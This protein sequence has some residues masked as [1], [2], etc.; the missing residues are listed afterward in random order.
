MYAFLD[1]YKQAADAADLPGGEW[2]KGLLG[3]LT[4]HQAGRAQ[5]LGRASEEKLEPAESFLVKHPV[6]SSIIGAATGGAAGGAAGLG[7]DIGLGIAPGSR[8]GL[9]IGLGGTV[10]G[11]LLG[12]LAVNQM[13]LRKVRQAREE[14]GEPAAAKLDQALREEAASSPTWRAV[15]GLFGPGFVYSG[16]DEQLASLK[17]GTPVKGG[18]LAGAS[19]VMS[20]IPYAGPLARLT[21]GSIMGARSPGI[22]QKA[23]A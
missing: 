14:F 2:Y 15:A 21:A 16:R 11:T 8:T 1:G 13:I 4:S 23:L 18:R 17:K 12:A 3:G 20:H 7:A 9:N 5:A 22:A 19:D 10:A 6:W